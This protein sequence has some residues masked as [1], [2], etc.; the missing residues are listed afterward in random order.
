MNPIDPVGVRLQATQLECGGCVKKE[1]PT[2]CGVVAN[3]GIGIIFCCWT[4]HH[5]RRQ[6]CCAYEQRCSRMLGE[7]TKNHHDTSL[8]VQLF[9]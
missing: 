2:G 7:G 4:T 1:I 6:Q 9:N 8:S 3:S 5:Q